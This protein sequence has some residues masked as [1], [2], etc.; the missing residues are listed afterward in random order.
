M[1]ILP[2]DGSAI[3][4]AADMPMDI[5]SNNPTTFS[6]RPTVLQQVPI[7]CNCKHQQLL[8]PQNQ[9]RKVERNPNRKKKK[10]QA[11]AGSDSSKNV[12][13]VTGVIRV[14]VTC[15]LFWFQEKKQSSKMNSGIP[16]IE[17]IL[18]AVCLNSSKKIYGAGKEFHQQ[19]ESFPALLQYAQEFLK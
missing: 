7:V 10:S 4:K 9:K 14:G 19:N 2:H 17:W 8:Q 3:L 13:A 6:D 16:K 11:M 12:A 5:R 15:W 18:D 1:K